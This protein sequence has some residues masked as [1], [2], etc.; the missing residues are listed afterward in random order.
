MY[1][2]L[3]KKVLALT[4][5]LGATLPLLGIRCPKRA[6]VM[7]LEVAKAPVV[8]AQVVELPA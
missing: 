8:P 4:I 5:A 3:R 1:K 6:Q 7:E 2:M